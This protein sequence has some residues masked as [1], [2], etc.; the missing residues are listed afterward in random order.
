MTLSAR[1][2]QYCRAVWRE[3]AQLPLPPLARSAAAAAQ[4]PRKSLIAEAVALPLLS[5]LWLGCFGCTS[6]R[7]RISATIEPVPAP[8]CAPASRA[9]RDAARLGQVPS[10]AANRCY[11]YSGRHQGGRP[12]PRRPSPPR[13]AI[14]PMHRTRGC[15]PALQSQRSAPTLSAACQRISSSGGAA[16]LSASRSALACLRLPAPRKSARAPRRVHH[17]D[18]SSPRSGE[19][20]PGQ[21]SRSVC[22]GA[23]SV[24]ATPAIARKLV[25]EKNNYT[26]N[27]PTQLSARAGRVI[28]R[29]RVR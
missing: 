17:D 26:S 21:S 19:S 29:A 10:A 28:R 27:L 13:G 22:Y 9:A 20:T 16:T 25:T 11:L 23:S 4:T 7:A 2:W 1:R 14:P 15:D 8:P 3:P 18:E 24:S 12:P 6:T 5:R